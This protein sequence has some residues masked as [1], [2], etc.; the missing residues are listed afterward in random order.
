MFLLLTTALASSDAAFTDLIA[1]E[2]LQD[3][4]TPDRDTITAGYAALC[5][6]GYQPACEPPWAFGDLASA[7][8]ALDARCEE[9]D[10]VACLVV[11][12]SLSQTE[13]GKADGAKETAP[14]ALELMTQ[15]CTDGLE[16]ACVEQGVLLERGVGGEP[17][18]NAILS[19]YQTACQQGSLAGCRR[20]GA[21]LHSGRLVPR[22]VDKALGYYTKACEGG[23]ASGCN[24]V[25]LVNHVAIDRERDPETAAK[26]YAMACS[27]GHQPACENLRK[28]YLAGI[29]AEQDPEAAMRILTDGCERGVPAACSR[30]ALVAV[31]L[32]Q[33][34]E[35]A[36]TLLTLSCDAGDPFTCGQLGTLLID[37]DAARAEPLLAKA[38]DARIPEPCA[39]LG[40]HHRKTPEK[41]VPLWKVAC[42]EQ[43]APSC[44]ALSTAAKKGKGLAKDKALAAEYQKMACEADPATC[45]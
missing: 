42:E 35:K 2:L 4:V 18:G 43:H 28:L 45:K 3:T 31:E 26:Y 9:K 32:L 23:Y 29:R 14:R 7:A 40:D 6:Q 13:P 44:M 34:R 38:C 33:D 36:K 27:A 15:A 12:W 24:S 10:P 11:A 17:D 30:G 22:D 5:E 39:V 21:L 8:E 20:L 16:R 1:T 41:A 37:E 19:L 25:G